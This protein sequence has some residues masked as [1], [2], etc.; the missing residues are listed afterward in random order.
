MRSTRISVLP[1]LAGVAALAALVTGAVAASAA[2]QDK[3]IAA[4]PP[5]TLVQPFLFWHDH[6]SYFL[7]AGGACETTPAGW[8]LNGGAAIVA[9][10]ESWHVNSAGDAASLGLP[11]G[12]AATSPPI[13]VTVHSPNIRLF[14]A[15]DGSTRS[16]LQVLLNYTDKHGLARTTTVG[17]L[18]GGSS[19]ALSP[20]IMFL[21][22]VSPVVGG[23]GQ[24]W[25]TF[26]FKPTSGGDWR[27]DDFYVDPIKSQ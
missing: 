22:F 12:S 9:G 27:I 18:R 16:A 14:S 1:R 24:T 21:R 25:V 26:T 6:S 13:C 2:G 20:Q 19:W 15:N 4:C 10:N 23:Q 3:T 11:T 7:A 17:T 5:Q 8:T